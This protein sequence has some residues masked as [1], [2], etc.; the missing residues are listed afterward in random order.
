[1]SNSNSNQPKATKTPKELSIHGQKRIDNYFWLNEKE[2]P[3]VIDYLN[4][5]NEYYHS[6]TA[7]T[8]TLQQE[9]FE[10]LKAR[11]KEEDQ[12]VPF[13]KNHY[14]YTTYMHVGQQYPV[15]CRKHES[16]D[17]IEQTLFDVNKMA[18]ENWNGGGHK[19]AAGGRSDE[20]MENTIEKLI[21]ILPRYEEDLQRTEI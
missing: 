4:A 3:A 2:N 11:I 14:I 17:A 20:S 6:K 18:R 9:L 19:N 5:E 10:E 1:M 12:S 8:N 15:F 16:E 21:S 13:K 7:H